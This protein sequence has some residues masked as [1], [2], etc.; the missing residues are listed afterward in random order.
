MKWIIGVDV[1]RRSRGALQFARWLAEATGESGKDAFV[2]VHVLDEEH[3]RMMLR[4][5]HL[6]DLVEAERSGVSRQ[7]ADMMGRGDLEPEIMQAVTVDDGLEAQRARENAT[8]VIVARAAPSEGR[9]VFRL[10]GVARRLLRRLA[11]PV[12]VVPPDLAASSIGDGPVVSLSSLEADSVAACRLARSIADVARRDLSV[13]YVEDERREKSARRGS[14]SVHEV[15]AG[16][17]AHR[18]RALAR[19]VA[20]HGV[21][22]DVASVIDG[23]PP[24]AAVAFSEAQ[25]APLVV[26]GAHR[27]KG[28]RSALEPKLW[29]SL[30]AHARQAVLVVPAAPTPLE[31]RLACGEEDRVAR[32]HGPAT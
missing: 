3:L 27:S 12:I 6:D 31:S 9:R 21:W 14:P 23:D 8:G 16:P 2:P 29:C 25:C 19:W 11:S 1:G 5:H 13:V 17:F 30:A 15:S 18:E 20:R 32:P 28:V 22:P 4:Y 26:V 10:G 7:I 24:S